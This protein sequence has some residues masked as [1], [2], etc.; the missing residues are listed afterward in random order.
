MDGKC[1]ESSYEKGGLKA[2][3]RAALDCALKVK[4]FINDTKSK[5]KINCKECTQWEL[6]QYP[7]FTTLILPSKYG[8]S[9]LGGGET[10]SM[11][12]QS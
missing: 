4:Q 11:Y 12:V 9:I 7:T 8:C 10:G 5:N 1:P 2:P 3:D 6:H